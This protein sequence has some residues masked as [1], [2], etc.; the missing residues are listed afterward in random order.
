MSL[1]FWVKLLNDDVSLM[2][3]CWVFSDT[4]G[5][6]FSSDDFH[7]KVCPS[8]SVSLRKGEREQTL[9]FIY[10]FVLKTRHSFETSL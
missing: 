3:I 1:I 6:Y 5:E 4:S 9:I 10:K 7:D 2:I 8:D